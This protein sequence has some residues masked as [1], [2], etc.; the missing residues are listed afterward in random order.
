VIQASHGGKIPWVEIGA[1]AIG[2]FQHQDPV[3][4]GFLSLLSL[5]VQKSFRWQTGGLYAPCLVLVAVLQPAA[6]NLLRG[7]LFPQRR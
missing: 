2:R 7:K 4:V 1:A 6:R 5:A 3:C